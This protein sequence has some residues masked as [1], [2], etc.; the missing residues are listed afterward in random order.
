MIAEAEN[1]LHGPTELA[2]DAINQ[3]RRRAFG[4]LLIGQTVKSITITSGGSG[5]STSNLPTITLTTPG[6]ATGSG[7]IAAVPSIS[8]GKITSILISSGGKNY[9]VP[10]IVTISGGAGVGATAVANITTDAD[11]DLPASSTADEIV[12]HTAIKEE[13]MR[14]FFTEGLR[15]ADLIRWGNFVGDMKAMIDY[16][17]AN[18]APTAFFTAYQNVSPRYLLLPIPTREIGLNKLLT[19]NPGF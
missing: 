3:V 2:K 17:I 6:G 5:Y 18:A 12:F 14:E 10:P 1:A 8:G 9:S 11:A 4:K 7:A 16:G 13:R 15:K 19:Q